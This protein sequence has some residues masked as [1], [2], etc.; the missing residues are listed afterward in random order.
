MWPSFGHARDWLSWWS[1]VFNSG[2]PAKYGKTNSECLR[3]FPQNMREATMAKIK[4]PNKPHSMVIF[5]IQ[6]RRTYQDLLSFQAF[7]K[8]EHEVIHISIKK[9]FL[10]SSKHNNTLFK[11]SY[12]VSHFS[13]MLEKLIVGSPIE[14][15]GSELF[16]IVFQKL[17]C[18]EQI[19]S[20]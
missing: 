6:L 13:R 11:H 2:F 9:T 19:F 1:N 15:N 3:G 17:P 18:Y 12:E 4:L 20:K 8:I 16:Q 7:K 10:D 5:W 14:M